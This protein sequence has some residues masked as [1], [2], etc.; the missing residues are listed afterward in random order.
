[1]R[2]VKKL[3]R[4]ALD[5]VDVLIAAALALVF[6][7]MGARNQLEGD[8][9]TQAAIG[10]LGALSF[11]IF[12][13]R[14]E[15]R[16]AVEGVDRAVQSIG[17]PRPWEVLDEKLTWDIRSPQSATCLSE[18]DLRVLGPEVFTIHEFERGT[19]GA[20]TQRRASGAAPG[21]PLAPL[22][23]LEPGILGPEGRMYHVI[24]L[25]RAW[26]RGERLRLRYERQLTNSFLAERENVSKQVQSETDRLVMRVAWPAEKP[27]TAVRLERTTGQN[28]LHPKTRQERARIEETIENPRVGEVITISW[29]W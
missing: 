6:T 1:M 22:R 17:R 2:W 28:A 9:L 26:T 24:C 18:R 11:V 5:Y 4:F 10:L 29:T 15:R 21:D 8:A 12:R 25:E 14:W 3:A 13:E 27:P 20:V 23:V 16:K 19:T 7:Y